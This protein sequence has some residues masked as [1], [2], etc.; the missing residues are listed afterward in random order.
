MPAAAFSSAAVLLRH[1]NAGHVSTNLTRRPVRRRRSAAT[2]ANWRMD[3]ASPKSSRSSTSSSTRSSEQY[4]DFVDMELDVEDIKLNM[5]VPTGDAELVPFTDDVG[6]GAGVDYDYE[7]P[8]GFALGDI[9]W[10]PKSD[11]VSG[12]QSRYLS[13]PGAYAIRNEGGTLQYVGCCSNVQ[14]RLLQLHA[15]IGGDKFSTVQVYMYNAA[16]GDDGG[17]AEFLE[18][19]VDYWVRIE[20][21]GKVPVGNVDR[22]W[23]LKTG[24]KKV[25]YMSVAAVFLVHSIAKQLAIYL[26]W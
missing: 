10:L 26:H 16:Y 6:D 3:A 24:E 9:P 15:T 14:K 7:L 17:V 8:H 19:V 20:L 4:V 5:H 18:G 21:D 2:A 11:A 22:S 23:E 13:R 25:L 12:A 1:R